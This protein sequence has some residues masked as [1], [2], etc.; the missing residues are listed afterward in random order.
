[1]LILILAAII[2]VSLGEVVDAIAIGLVVLLNGILGFVQEWR[3]ENA[4]QALRAMMSPTALVIRDGREQVVE[5]RELVPD[6]VVIL[7]TGDRIPADLQ[8]RQSIQLKV[9]ESVLTGE[10]VAVDKGTLGDESTVFAGTSVIAGRA[11]GTVRTTGLNTEFGKIAKLTGGVTKGK[12]QLQVHLGKLAGQ[13]GVVALLIACLVV[14]VG[15]W[16]GREMSELFM[17]GLSLAV[18]I[19][20]EGLPAVVTITLALGATA[21]ARRNAVVR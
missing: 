4:L 17:T 6:D 16:A 8:L 11:E 10:S 2:A 19:V 3:A 20:P 12:T 13:L 7:A 15:L 18:A 1:V 21:M 5:A 14:G 9:D